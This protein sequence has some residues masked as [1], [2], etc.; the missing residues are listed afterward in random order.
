MAK[1]LVPKTEIA[2]NQNVGC[3]LSLYI[4]LKFNNYEKV[5]L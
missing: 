2:M 3:L 1:S 4:N 5:P